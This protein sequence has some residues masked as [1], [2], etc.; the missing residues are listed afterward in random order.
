[1]ISEDLRFSRFYQVDPE[2]KRD[3]LSDNAVQLKLIRTPPTNFQFRKWSYNEG[4]SSK[5]YL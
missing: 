5:L 4:K 3:T 2:Q 1:M